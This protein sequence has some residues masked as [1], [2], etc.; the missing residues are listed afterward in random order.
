M[1]KASLWILLSAFVIF[2]IDWGVMGVKLLEGNYDIMTEA[3][4]ALLCFAVIIVCILVRLLGRKCPHCKKMLLT[5][6]KFCPHCGK[7]IEKSSF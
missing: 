6:G 5:D 3:Y 7:P 2:L 4:I 1:K